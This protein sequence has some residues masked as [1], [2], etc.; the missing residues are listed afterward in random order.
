[1]YRYLKG[2]LGTQITGLH[3]CLRVAD[4]L[5]LGCGLRICIPNKVPGDA[6]AADL[7]PHFENHHLRGMRLVNLGAEGGLKSTPIIA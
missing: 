4:S 1:V 2:L 7:G 3:P 5:G 6:D